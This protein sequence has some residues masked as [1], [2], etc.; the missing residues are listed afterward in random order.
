MKVSVTLE[1]DTLARARKVAGH[2]GLSSYVDDALEEKLA[3]DETRQAWLAY[4][5][6]LEANDPTPQH[7]KDAAHRRVV[8][9]HKL[10]TS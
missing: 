9:L 8:E 3:R 6:E 10:V 2:R 1:E 5:D 7:I 4:L